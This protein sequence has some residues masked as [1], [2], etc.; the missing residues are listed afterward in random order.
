M[1]YRGFSYLHARLLLAVQHDIEGLESEL[2]ELDRIDSIN[3]NK[4]RLLS[5][6]RDEIEARKGGE[7]H[8]ERQRPAV[9]AEL[10]KRLMAYGMFFEIA[11][12][13]R[14]LP[15]SQN[16]VRPNSAESKESERPSAPCGE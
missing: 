1:Q 5:K 12:S 3:G 13:L 2:D 15:F 14:P 10:E 9:L 8:V 4:R 16:N 6:T 7:T 11:D